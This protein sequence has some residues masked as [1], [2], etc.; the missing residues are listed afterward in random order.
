MVA[1]SPVNF[2]GIGHLAAIVQRACVLVPQQKIEPKT[3]DEI[4]Y[5]SH[6]TQTTI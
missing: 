6:T 2:F 4:F 5:T 1:Q 3:G